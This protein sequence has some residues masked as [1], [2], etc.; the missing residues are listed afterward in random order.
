VGK[1]YHLD[2]IGCH[3]DGW[4]KPMG[5]CRI[6]KTAD[7]EQV[8]CESCHGPGTTHLANPVK[9]NMPRPQKEVCMGCHDHENSPHFDFETYV[10]KI[11]GPGHGLP[12]L[13]PQ[14]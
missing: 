13:Q 1:Q 3:V 14:P 12:K 2:C 7:R 5:V 9:E 10:L 8:S 4:Q 11:R 6:D